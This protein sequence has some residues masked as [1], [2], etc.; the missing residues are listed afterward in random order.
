MIV[1]KPKL[2]LEWNFDCSDTIHQISLCIK[3]QYLNSLN[4]VSNG[5]EWYARSK[6]YVILA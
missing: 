2:W 1:I 5:K 3:I 4:K 6:T